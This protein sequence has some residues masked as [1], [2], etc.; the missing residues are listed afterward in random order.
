MMPAPLE[1]D[2][3]STTRRFSLAGVVVLALGAAAA[4]WTVVDYRELALQSTLIEMQL[5]AASPRT[6]RSVRT[7]AV[8]TRGIEEATDAV[9]ELSLPWSQL[10]DDLEAAGETSRED[11]SLLS[12]EPDREKRRVRIGAE[13]RTLP[14]ALAFVGQLQ[15]ASSLAYPLL[16]NHKVRTEV[17]ERPVYFEMTADWKLSQ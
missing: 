16:D 9:L 5:D 11:I 1:L 6:S 7:I 13:A 12:I 2:F 17:R 10:L 14:A 15:S 3:V 8:D 4:A